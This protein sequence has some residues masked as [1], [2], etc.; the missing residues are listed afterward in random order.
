MGPF[1]T[2]RELAALFF[3]KRN[4]V[5]LTGRPVLAFLY[6]LGGCL[7]DL[8]GPMFWAALIVG[9]LYAEIFLN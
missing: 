6:A 2:D 1:P 7:M 9:F 3:E 4:P 5:D 8:F